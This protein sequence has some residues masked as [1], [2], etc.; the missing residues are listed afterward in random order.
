MSDPKPATSPK[1][2]RGSAL[3]AFFRR[4]EAGAA[5]GFLLI[6]IFFS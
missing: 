3:S 5:A 1:A 6:L 4:P 2:T